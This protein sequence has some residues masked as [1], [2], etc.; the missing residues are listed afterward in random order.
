MLQ[1]NTR[2]TTSTSF[3]PAEEVKRQYLLIANKIHQAIDRVAV[4]IHDFFGGTI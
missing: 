4:T 2:P 3:I 1:E